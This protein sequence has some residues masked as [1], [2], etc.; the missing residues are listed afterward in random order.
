MFL[1]LLV[2]TMVTLSV[3]SASA[4]V[5]SEKIQGI[6]DNLEY[7]LS[8]QWD[9]KDQK[10]LNNTLKKF[11][12]ELIS[13]K[14]EG[15]TANDLMDHLKNS[16]LSDDLSSSLELVVALINPDKM[17]FSDARGFISDFMKDSYSQGANWVGRNGV[18]MWLTYSLI[19]VAVGAMIYILYNSEPGTGGSYYYCDPYYDPYCDP[20]YDPYYDPFCDPYYDPYCY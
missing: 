12:G 7:S 2:T 20:Y 18:P 11:E 13:L 4:S 16:V 15:L 9:Q 1:K 17:K 5:K 8:V 14:S 3:L 6:L 10:F 19:A